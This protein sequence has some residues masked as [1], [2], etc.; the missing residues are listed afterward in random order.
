MNG[1]KINNLKFA[2]DIVLIGKNFWELA[3]VRK[4]L[5]KESAKVGL[6]MN[7]YKTQ[8][9]KNEE[10]VTSISIEAWTY[11]YL[12]KVVSFTEGEKREISAR[13]A[14][15]WRTF[16]AIIFILKSKVNLLLLSYGCQTCSL[17][18]KQIKKTPNMSCFT[19]Y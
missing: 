15:A 17:T 9:A 8:V 5:K 16:W 7:T 1:Q 3:K 11:K 12:K 4:E 10:S 6:S 14:N 2:D 19:V 13:I 18:R